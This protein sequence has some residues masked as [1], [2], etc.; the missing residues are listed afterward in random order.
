MFHNGYLLVLI[1]HFVF[2]VIA[3]IDLFLNSRR[4]RKLIWALAIGLV[5]VAG[6]VW[7]HV[8]KRRN[9]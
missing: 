6:I 5:P 9:A 1:I 8:T 3:I 4:K 7:Y 2:V